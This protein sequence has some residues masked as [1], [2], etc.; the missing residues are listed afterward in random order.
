MKLILAGDG[1]LG[2]LKGGKS[3][4][5]KR[6]YFQQPAI[7]ILQFLLCS[8]IMIY[9]FRFVQTKAPNFFL[10]IPKIHY[11]SLKINI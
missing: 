9:R 7:E 1:P 11:F 2:G 3:L 5:I 10:K 6:F 4:N 8:I